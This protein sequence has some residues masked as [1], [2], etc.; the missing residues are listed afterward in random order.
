MANCLLALWG[1]SVSCCL[2]PSASPSCH[3]QGSANSRPKHHCAPVLWKPLSACCPQTALCLWKLSCQHHL[4]Q[5]AWSLPEFHDRHALCPLP[6]TSFLALCYLKSLAFLLT[7]LGG[8]WWC[9]P[10]SLPSLKSSPQ[11]CLG[12]FVSVTIRHF[13]M[14]SPCP[15]GRYPRSFA[16]SFLKSLFLFWGI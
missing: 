15:R 5:E 6:V 3:Q 13:W 16:Q 10:L 11:A 7:R 1:W 14:P 9:N 8:P 12:A 2:Q 4:L